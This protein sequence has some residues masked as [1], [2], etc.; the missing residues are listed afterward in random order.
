MGHETIYRRKNLTRGALKQFIKPYLLRG[1]EIDRAN[2]VWFSDI[3]YIPMAK[4]LMYMTAYIDVYSIKSWVGY[5]QLRPRIA[6]YESQLDKLSGGKKKQ[7]INGWQRTCN[8]Q[9]LDRALLE[10]HQIQ[11]YLSEPLRYMSWT[12]W[13]SSDLYRVL[14]QQETP[15]HWDETQWRLLQ[16]IKPKCC[17]IQLEILTMHHYPFS[18]I[19]WEY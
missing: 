10:K 7:N 16:I 2:Q 3:T 18:R 1:L 4:G 5:Q 9:Y 8:R 19:T 14:S 15:R 11:P 12:I 17:M 13:R 6:V